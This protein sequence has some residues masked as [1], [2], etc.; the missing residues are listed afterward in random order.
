M[1]KRST[2][3]RLLSLVPILGVFLFTMLFIYA[4]TLYPGGSQHD[5]ESIGFD[6]LHNYWCNLYMEYSINGE[7]NI[8]RPLAIIASSILCCSMA[9]FFYL[10]GE[11]FSKTN[12]TKKLLTTSG[13]VSM[14]FASL[15]FTSFHDLMTIL[16]SIFG[17]VCVILIILEMYRSRHTFYKWMGFL[18]IVLLCINNVIYYISIGIKALPLL[19]K[20]TL[21]IVLFWVV[22]LSMLL[23]KEKENGMK[24]M[25]E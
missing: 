22:G 18:C 5:P 1:T 8:A 9:V 17:I 15:M 21:F 3:N 14:I 7:L 11:H 12:N 23:W 20:V 2:Y 25:K 19:Q 16:S 6:W 13:I 24:H 4:S 10:F